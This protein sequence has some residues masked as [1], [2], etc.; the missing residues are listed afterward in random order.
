[1]QNTVFPD[2]RDR[3]GK[4]TRT[5]S[6]VSKQADEQEN[7]RF[8]RRTICFSTTKE[9]HECLINV[10]LSHRKMDIHCYA[11]PKFLLLL[12]DKPCFH[13]TFSLDVNQAAILTDKVMLEN[14]IDSFGY[15]NF[16]C[17]TMRFH[18]AGSIDG[19]AP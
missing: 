13:Q 17:F 3:F 6:V 16:A 19:I 7:R 18:S 12:H 11:L 1:M 15:M 4:S 10:Y 9:Y 8:V 2:D 5:I 14:V